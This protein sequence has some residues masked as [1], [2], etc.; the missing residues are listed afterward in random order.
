MNAMS[1]NYENELQTEI[2]NQMPF[3]SE[4]MDTSIVAFEYSGTKFEQSF[5][6]LVKSKEEGG[7]GY[8]KIRR[9]R[10]DGNCFYRAFLFQLFEH[11]ALNMEQFKT[12]YES[13]IKIV[14]DSKDDLVKNAGYEEM[15]IEDFY[16]VF[17]DHVKKLGKLQEEFDA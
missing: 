3:I 12:Q 2:A 8:T 14:T 7:S 17:L 15:V 1:T 10:R 16:D 13:L 5:G 6:M 4:V 11:Y 9:L